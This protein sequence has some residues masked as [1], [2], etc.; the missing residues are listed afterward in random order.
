M[1][2]RPDCVAARAGFCANKLRARRLI[3]VATS[4]DKAHAVARTVRE[5]ISPSMPASLLRLH[6]D[7]TLVLTPDAASELSEDELGEFEAA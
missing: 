7:A 4:A 6:A 1:R 3:L 2:C 5:P